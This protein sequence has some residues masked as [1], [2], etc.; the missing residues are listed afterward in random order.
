[1]KQFGFLCGIQ[2]STSASIFLSISICFCVYYLKSSA[3]KMGLQESSCKTLSISYLTLLSL[4]LIFS[5]SGCSLPGIGCCTRFFSASQ[6]LPFKPKTLVA[7]LAKMTLWSLPQFS[8]TAFF[9]WKKICY[10]CSSWP[11]FSAFC[12]FSD[13][14]SKYIWAALFM[15]SE[16]GLVFFT[17][18]VTNIVTHWFGQAFIFGSWNSALISLPHFP[19]KS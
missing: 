15:H 5:W 4:P 10:Q 16:T 3:P 14:Y 12:S 19:I 17:H 1:M 11:S 2:D 8:E 13:A 7:I 9:L 18:L 6:Q